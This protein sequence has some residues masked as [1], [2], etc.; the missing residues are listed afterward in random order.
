[1]SDIYDLKDDAQPFIPVEPIEA[2]KP[3]SNRT[4]W[5]I[6]IA[7]VVILFLCCCCIAGLVIY[8][9]STYTFDASMLDSM[10]NNFIY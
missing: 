10:R 2:E 6:L 5:M 9:F 4:L 7:I 8:G 3:N 1:M